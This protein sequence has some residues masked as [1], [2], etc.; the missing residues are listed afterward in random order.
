MYGGGGGRICHGGK[1]KLNRIRSMHRELTVLLLKAAGF[2]AT[3]GASPQIITQVAEASVLML[4]WNE[5]L[6]VALAL[7]L[8]R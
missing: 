1:P 3:M 8:G 7:R 4:V 2:A 5:T 6:T